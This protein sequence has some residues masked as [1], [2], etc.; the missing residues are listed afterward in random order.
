MPHGGGDKD[1]RGTI[2]PTNDADGILTNAVSGAAVMK[3]PQLIKEKGQGQECKKKEQGAPQLAATLLLRG[4][5]AVQ[6][7]KALGKL[8]DLSGF[9]GLHGG[10]QQC[11][12]RRIQRLGQPDQKIGI[13]DGQALLPFGN[14]LTHHMD[15]FRQFLL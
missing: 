6:K 3:R 5:F 1:R 11:A 15:L 4:Q 8:L 12:D 7:G 14:C 2:Y 13:R 10:T 9:C